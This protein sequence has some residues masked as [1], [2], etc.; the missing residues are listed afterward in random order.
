MVEVGLGLFERSQ[1]FWVGGFDLKVGTKIS[2]KDQFPAWALPP[3][4]FAL[5]NYYFLFVDTISA[6]ANIRRKVNLIS[7]L[8]DREGNWTSNEEDIAHILVQDFKKRFHQDSPPSA[9]NIM[10]FISIINPEITAEDNNVL[11][12]QITDDEILEAP[13]PD[14][15]QRKSGR[16]GAMAVKLDL[17][18]AYD[19]LDWSYIKACLLRFGFHYDWIELVMHCVKSVSFSIILN[20]SPQGWFQPSRG[21]HNV[22]WWK[23]PV[24]AKELLQRISNKLSGWKQSTLSRAGKLTLIKA[25]ISG[26]PNHVM[27]CFRCPKNLTNE[28]DKQGRNFLWGSDMKQAPVAWK[29][30]CKPKALGGLG[31]GKSIKFWSINWVFDHP[32]GELIPTHVRNNINLDELVS[33]YFNENGWNS[34]VKLRSF[35]DE[36]IVKEILGVPIPTNPS[37]DEFTKDLWTNSNMSPPISWNEGFFK[38]IHNWFIEN[39]YDSSFYEKLITICWQVWKTRNDTIFRGKQP[40]PRSTL[41]AAMSHLQNSANLCIVGSTES[42]YEND[43]MISCFNFGSTTIPVAEALALRN[44]L[45]DAKR[46]GFKKV[47]VEGDSKLVIDVINGVSA[48]PWRLLKLCQDIKS[49]RSSF[50]FISFK[51]VFRRQTLWLTPLQ[52]LVIG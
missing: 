10:D 11:L 32:L 31:D 37:A 39:P 17:E 5:E 42:N 45:I 49:L 35:L 36:N 27:S 21:I 29:D 46:R 48:P 16:N 34:T 28:I 4:A 22:V 51:H 23:D 20:G 3:S 15:F 7:K 40:N 13:G 1:N 24:N 19:L 38:V 9:A 41:A 18:K 6:Q 43:K 2:G 25:N 26:M 14:D 47:E 52:T 44:G 30:I 8:Q 50:E 12:K 33:D